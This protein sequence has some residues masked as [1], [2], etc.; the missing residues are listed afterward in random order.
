VKSLLSPGER[1]AAR[2]MLLT[3]VFFL[4]TALVLR[5]DMLMCLFIMLALQT[6]FEQYNGHGKPRDAF[7]FPFYIFLALFT[8]GPVG[9]IVP[10]LSTIIFLLL[11]AD[12]KAIGRFW[13]LKTILVLLVL[14]G[15]WFSGVYLEGGSRYLNDLLFHQ[16]IN[17][18]VNSFHHQEP[19][20]YY[21][22]AFWYTLAPWSLLIAGS[23]VVGLR[24]WM[25][26]SD[27]ELFFLTVALSTFSILTAFSSKLAIYLLPAFPFFIYLAA[28]WLNRIG[29]PKWALWVT[30][31]PSAILV[32]VF[33]AMVLAAQIP[34]IRG[35]GISLPVYIAA[36]VLSGAA[37]RAIVQLQRNQLNPAVISLGAGI[38][39]AVFSTS[40]ALPKYNNYIGLANICRL[41]R[42]Q[43]KQTGVVK[44]YYFDIRQG[45]SMDVYLETV[46]ERITVKDLC[47]RYQQVKKPAILFT[48]NIA[49]QRNDSLRSF[50]NGKTAMRSG[51]YYYVELK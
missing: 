18:A 37:V 36:F 20:Y 30:G 10:L 22:V 35:I 21:F 44:Y 26:S 14:C 43:A 33:P 34:A 7:L 1:R 39:L 9:V 45:N 3:S 40:F 50:I 16:T 38:F 31:I 23:L 15:I 47:D 5:M 2:L 51:G 46:P 24:K 6:F 49:V 27:I 4:G 41:A 48:R 32:L 13:G 25:V 17:R 19:L 8:K 12:Y 29:S 28:L 42:D 11:K